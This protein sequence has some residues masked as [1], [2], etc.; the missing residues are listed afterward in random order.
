MSSY[1]Y[2]RLNLYRLAH[3]I[4]IL[5]VRKRG[6]C[7]SIAYPFSATQL[8]IDYRA[9]FG[10]VLLSRVSDLHPVNEEATQNK[11]RDGKREQTEDGPKGSHRFGNDCENGQRT[12]DW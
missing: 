3:P 9:R 10:R 8:G 7:T 4:P 11:N 5:R 2:V 6:D 1:S 12:R